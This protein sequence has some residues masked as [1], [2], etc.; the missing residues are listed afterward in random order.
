MTIHFKNYPFCEVQNTSDMVT[1]RSLNCWRVNDAQKEAAYRGDRLH[2]L[3][4]V[5]YAQGTCLMYLI[6]AC[7]V[8][9]SLVRPRT[10]GFS[11]ELGR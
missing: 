2:R 1:K 8:M 6:V 7:G 9:S 5:G 10:A 3:F 4:F 11:F